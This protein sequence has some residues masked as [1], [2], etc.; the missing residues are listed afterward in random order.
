MLYALN[1]HNAIYQLYLNK[2][3]KF[4]NDLKERVYGLHGSWPT[5]PRGTYSSDSKPISK[6]QIERHPNALLIL[7]PENLQTCSNTC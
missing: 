3:G 7:F 6:H 2:A 5:I 1:L 4:F